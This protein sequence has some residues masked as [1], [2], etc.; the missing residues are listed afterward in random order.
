MVEVDGVMVVHSSSST[1]IMQQF[2]EYVELNCWQQKVEKV[3]VVT[4]LHHLM[5]VME[6]LERDYI[7]EQKMLVQVRTIIKFENGGTNLARYKSHTAALRRQ[8]IDLRQTGISGL[9]LTT[10]PFHADHVYISLGLLRD[11]LARLL[12]THASQFSAPMLMARFSSSTLAQPPIPFQIAIDSYK[13][14]HIK[15]DRF[16]LLELQLHRRPLPSIFLIFS[17]FSLPLNPW[18][19]GNKIGLRKMDTELCGKGESRIKQ[20]GFGGVGGMGFQRLPPDFD[21][22]DERLQREGESAG[23]DWTTPSPSSRS[24]P[25]SPPSE[26]NQNGGNLFLYGFFVEDDGYEPKSKSG[27]LFWFDVNIKSK[28]K[29]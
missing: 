22:F 29:I 13:S 26:K 1:I 19:G 15:S 10:E 12:C 23:S 16:T 17:I 4:C 3:K 25:P 14:I 7:S 24:H 5:D 11:S 18:N 2:N 20:T 6:R 27:K 8:K 9:R 21:T 28:Y